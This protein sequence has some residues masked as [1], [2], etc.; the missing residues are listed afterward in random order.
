MLVIGSSPMIEA[1]P[2]FF[3]TSRYGGMTLASMA[4]LFTIATVATY[5]LL[6]VVSAEGAARVNLGPIERY[7]EVLSGAL[8]ML[9]GALFALW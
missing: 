2:T 9:L 6:C 1:I 3:A 4:A 8:V 7:G 5:V